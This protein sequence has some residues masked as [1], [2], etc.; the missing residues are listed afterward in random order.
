M[1]ENEGER[2][3]DGDD[4][5]LLVAEEAERRGDEIELGHA[6]ADDRAD[7]REPTRP[8]VA[9]QLSLGRER[10]DDERAVGRLDLSGQLRPRDRRAPR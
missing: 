4:L 1:R 5:D 6:K 7:A 2:D 3:E 8:R 10:V 9:G